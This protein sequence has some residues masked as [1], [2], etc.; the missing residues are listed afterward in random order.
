M[1]NL[2][3]KGVRKRFGAVE[4]LHGLDL[5]VRNGAFCVFVGPSG[6]GRFPLNLP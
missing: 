1:A 3:M 5:Q 4:I 2:A 6:C